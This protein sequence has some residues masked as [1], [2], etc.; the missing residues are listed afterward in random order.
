VVRG[1]ARRAPASVP[2]QRRGTSKG[3]GTSPA[4][5]GWRF[6]NG[7]LAGLAGFERRLAR[8]EK[9][10]R[11]VPEP[12]PDPRMFVVATLVGFHSCL[13]GFM[14]VPIVVELLLRLMVRRG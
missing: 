8:I 1:A 12:P 9:Q 6:R 3:S 2:A 10:Q 4:S 7:A 11:P 14:S 13:N 5:S